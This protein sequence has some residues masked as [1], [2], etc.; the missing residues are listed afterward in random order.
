MHKPILF[1]L[2]FFSS[3][4]LAVTVDKFGVACEAGYYITA[5][6]KGSKCEPCPEGFYNEK[7]NSYQV[8]RRNFLLLKSAHR[9]HRVPILKNQN[10]RHALN[11]PLEHTHRFQQRSSVSHVL[12]TPL[13]M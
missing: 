6:E 4:I 1:I 7:S 12:S 5:A 11:V 8:R 13:A 3:V 9:V 10:Q 2:A